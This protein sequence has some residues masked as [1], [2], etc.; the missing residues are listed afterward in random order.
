MSNSQS[1]PVRRY[2]KVLQLAAKYSQHSYI[3]HNIQNIVRITFL[4]FDLLLLR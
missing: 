4:F 1:G 3:V 2:Y